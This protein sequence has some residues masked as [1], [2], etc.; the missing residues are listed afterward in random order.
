MLMLMIVNLCI[1][2][3]LTKNSRLMKLFFRFVIQIYAYHIFSFI[4]SFFLHLIIRTSFFI[5]LLQ[6]I[7]LDFPF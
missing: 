3:N 6:N 1:M 7:F 5:F 4:L 2:L